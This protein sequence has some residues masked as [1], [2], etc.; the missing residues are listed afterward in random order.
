[1][2]PRPTEAGQET[3]PTVERRRF[4][5]ATG[6]V[7]AGTVGVVTVSS[8]GSAKSSGECDG[9][10]SSVPRITSYGHFETSWFSSPS[11]T[12]GNTE[13]NVDFAGE[14]IPG[15]DA[16][17]PAELLVHVHGWRNDDNT[18]AC[19]IARTAGVYA[20]EGYDHPVTGLTWDA[21]TGWFSGTE[22]A[23]RNGAKLAA[24]VSSYAS[25]NPGTTIRLSCHS[26]GA[27][28]VLEALYALD[29]DG[30]HD[31]VTSASIMGGSAD[32]T[33][34]SLDG[35]YGESIERAAGHV[36]NFW[37]A[38]DQILTYLYTLGEWSS[39]VGATGVDG[40]APSNYTDHDVSYVPDHFSHYEEDGCIGDIVETFDQA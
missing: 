5:R 30:H 13:T 26:L 21:D 23:E 37:M 17:A 4:L 34:V 40:P 2:Q 1:M 10:Y 28:V 38:D 27:R 16:A 12:D 32:A 6:A 15:V 35:R 31:V 11:L 7:T 29:E 24:F 3:Q 25:D 22:I 33:D 18:G 36:D 14:A 19:R 20:D 8:A 39:A 9:S